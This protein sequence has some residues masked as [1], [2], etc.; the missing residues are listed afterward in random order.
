MMLS[1]L[2]LSDGPSDK[3]YNCS[4]HLSFGTASIK[5]LTIMYD[6]VILAKETEKIVIKENLR[7]YYRRGRGEKWY[8][9]IARALSAGEEL[10][11]AKARFYGSYASY[12]D[13]LRIQTEK[14]TEMK[15]E[16]FIHDK[17]YKKGAFEEKE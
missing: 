10:K 15:T 12:Y 13:A 3:Q 1:Y 8:G 5:E 11:E 16:K 17:V 14:L 2:S 9:G 7:K 6:P 4:T